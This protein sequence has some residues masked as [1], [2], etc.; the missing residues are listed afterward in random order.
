MTD[1]RS[2]HIP[3][4]FD[5]GHHKEFTE[6]VNT[7]IADDSI[8]TLVLDFNRT[9]YLDSSA[10][11]MLVLAN[12]KAKEKSM[13]TVIRGARDNAKEILEIANFDKLFRIE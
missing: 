4:R 8:K 13:Q 7:V 10:L 1:S 12:K 6:E 2:I 11:G 9:S 5:F 3:E